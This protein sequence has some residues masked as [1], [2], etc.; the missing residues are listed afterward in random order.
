M[1]ARV[2]LLPVVRCSSS[3]CIDWPCHKG[4]VGSRSVAEGGH[5]RQFS[6]LELLETPYP[7][8]TALCLELESEQAESANDRK[9]AAENL[10][11]VK[12]VLL[13]CKQS[14]HL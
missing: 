5:L 2:K 10:R 8:L 11:L 14:V 6:I 13:I 7:E 3:S 9:V 4:D 1:A 12:F